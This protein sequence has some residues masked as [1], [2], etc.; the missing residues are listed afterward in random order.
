MMLKLHLNCVT[1]AENMT[2]FSEVQVKSRNDLFSDFNNILTIVNKVHVMIIIR[3]G[4]ADHFFL[5]V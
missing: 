1:K 2:I 5:F 3:L 4:Y